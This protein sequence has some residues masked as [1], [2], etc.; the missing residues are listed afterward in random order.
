MSQHNHSLEIV[1]LNKESIS[2]RYTF[3][4]KNQEIGE[5]QNND[6]QNRGAPE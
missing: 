6:I 4:D 2:K 5:L 3:K 1:L